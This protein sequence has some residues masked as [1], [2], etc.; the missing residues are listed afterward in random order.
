[1]LQPSTK[2]SP[3]E[4]QYRLDTEDQRKAIFNILEDVTDQQ[5]AL[6]SKLQQVQVLRET[7][8]KLTTSMLPQNIMN[9]VAG[10]IDKIVPYYTLS[11]IIWHGEGQIFSNIVYVYSKGS[12]GSLYVSRIQSDLLAFIKNINISGE[13]FNGASLEEQIKKKMYP[14][15]LSG[16]YSNDVTLVPQSSLVIPFTLREGESNK[17]YIMGMFHISSIN[18]KDRPTED[19][20]QIMEDIAK[21]SAI[22]VERIKN[23]AAIEQA[24]LASLLRSMSNGVI[25]FD[26]YR[27]VL[28]SNPAALRMTGLG[29]SITEP[30]EKTILFSEIE[31]IFVK[32]IAN[33][34][35]KV[36]DVLS[37]GEEIH[38]EEFNIL[39]FTY[40]IFL[41]PVRDIE[42]GITGGAIILHDITHTKEVSRMESEFI[43]TASHQLRTPMT[44]IQWVIERFL[45]TEKLTKQGR[46][47]LDDIRNSLSRL[48]TLVDVLLNVSRIEGG[49][50]GISPRP[51]DFV[52]FL[53]D[54]LNECQPLLDKKQISI[55]LTTKLNELEIK[56]DSGALRNIV[57]SII[58]NA[59]EY[60]PNKGKVTVS[61]EKVDSLAKFTVEDN[62][63]G[64]PK[65]EQK[66]IFDKFT[67]ATNAKKVKT[68]GTG[69]GMYIARQ[70][71][72]LL[73]G[74]LW[75]ESKVG[76][77]T[78]FFVELPL[79]SKKKEGGKVFQ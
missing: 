74:K 2:K 75:F 66:D 30:Q 56:T 4:T 57:Q 23:I 60:T 47:Y 76:K 6:K 36:A 11:Y 8:E 44:G 20:I 33:F 72:D 78:K 40:E 25:L 38:V 29:N 17:K 15:F 70:A 5:I 64:I 34:D 68:D 14:E 73:G 24:R 79:E 28:L 31:K 51:V 22:N 48:T 18:P 54:Y 9:I 49:R 32:G 16:F 35:S 59:I 50:V 67:R 53:K 7:L 77:G 41:T 45:K 3:A 12:V 42:G 19:E 61:L 37:T 27:N 71:I 21:I 10:S 46:E 55:K 52:G 39:R 13:I 63:I 1:M 26:Q 58:S 69:L 43:S 62:G 65:D